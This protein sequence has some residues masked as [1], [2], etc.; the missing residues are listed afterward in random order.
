MSEPTTID[1]TNLFSILGLTAAVWAVIPQS[2]R[3][4][5]RFCMTRLDWGIAIGVIFLAHYLTFSPVLQSMGLYHSFGPWRWGLD[6]SSAVYLLLLAAII[7]FFWRSRSPMLSRNK[8]GVFHEMVENLLCSGRYDE[9]VLFVEPQLLMLIRLSESSPWVA[10]QSGRIRLRIGKSKVVHAN[11]EPSWF[12]WR[13]KLN[14]KLLKLEGWSQKYYKVNDAARSILLDIVTTPDMIIHIAIA[15]PYFGLNLLKADVVR[16]SEFIEHFFDALLNSPGTRLYV[17][18]KNNLNTELGHKLQLPESNRMLYSFF[19]DASAAINLGLD[20]AIGEAICQRLDED[21]KLVELL[22]NPL[23]YYKDKG[24]FRCPIN[25]GIS[26]FEIMVHE[27]LHQGLQ[28]HMWLHYFDHFARK[29]I[30]QMPESPDEENFVEWPTPFHYLLYRLVSV[31]TDWVEQCEYIDDGDILPEIS[32]KQPFD[33]FYISKQAAIVVGAILKEII[34]AGKLSFKFRKGIL[35]NVMLSYRNVKNKAKI[36]PSVKERFEKCIMYGGEN[37]EKKTY[38]SHLY[39]VFS[40]IDP[41]LRFELEEFN[42]NLKTA[43]EVEASA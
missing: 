38:C 16:L 35:E 24:R 17:E 19:N 13:S 8:I 43:A 3:L 30:K 34:E 37:F 22:N 27:G 25:S 26:L 39:N 33:K 1:V 41:H 5:F 10:E 9:L 42:A 23:G 15:R 40:Q 21:E 12:D 4:R 11:I 28:D 2:S 36:D 14:A 32:G 20:R 29:I 6:S 18:L 7:Y 31:S